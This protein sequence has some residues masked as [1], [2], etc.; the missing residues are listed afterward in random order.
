MIE[1]LE[2]YNK[3][4]IGVD[5][6]ELKCKM[7]TDNYYLKENDLIIGDEDFGVKVSNIDHYNIAIHENEMDICSKGTCI[8][9]IGVVA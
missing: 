5:T 2:K 9:V 8:M 6:E 7:Y 3:Y 4:V 1:F